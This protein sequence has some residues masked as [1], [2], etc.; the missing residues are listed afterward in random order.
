MESYDASGLPRYGFVD[1]AGA[2]VIEP[3]FFYAASFL[4][5]GQAEV[6]LE[7]P[8]TLT[9]SATPAEDDPYDLHQDRIDKTGTVVWKRP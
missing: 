8:E 3:R 4:N 6:D 7:D 5:W 1:R 2:W 9:G